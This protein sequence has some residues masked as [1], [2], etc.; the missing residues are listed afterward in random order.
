[1]APRTA[2]FSAAP[3]QSSPAQEA[4]AYTVWDV[5]PRPGG[6]GNRLLGPEMCPRQPS[7]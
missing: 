6:G 7:C 2:K 1:M 3:W 5:S 4:A